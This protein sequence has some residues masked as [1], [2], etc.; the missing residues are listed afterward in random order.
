M[1]QANRS[2]RTTRVS[3]GHALGYPVERSSAFLAQRLAD[4]PFGIGR[5]EAYLAKLGT[6]L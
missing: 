6:R 3:G 5:S 2:F 4:L 1:L